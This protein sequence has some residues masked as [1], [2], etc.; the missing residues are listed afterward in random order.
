M[1]Q[2]SNMMSKIYHIYKATTFSKQPIQNVQ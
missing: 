1:Y 2:E